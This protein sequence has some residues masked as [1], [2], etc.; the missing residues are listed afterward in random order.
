MWDLHL[1]HVLTAKMLRVNS[2]A[3]KARVHQV[4]RA[5]HDRGLEALVLYANGSVLGNQSFMHA[6]LRY[7]C[8]FD[9]H[10]TPAMLIVQPGKAPT[11]LTGNKP[12]MRAHLAERNL[13]FDDVRHVQPP[14]LGDEIVSILAVAGR[15]ARRIAYMGYNETPAPVWKSLEQGLPR[16][17]WIHD[18]APDIDKCRVRKTAVEM[19]FHRRA[20]EVCDAMFETLAREVAT[21]KHGYRLKAAMEHTARDSGCDYCDTWLTLA[22]RADVFRYYM[23]E[24]FNAPQAG[25]Q[26]L[27]GV[28]LTYDGHWGHSVRT[29]SIGRATADHRRIYGICRDM[30]EAALE[31]LRPGE[32]LRGVNA[33]MDDILHRHYAEHEVRRSRS[34]HG[35]GYAYEDPVV[36]LA[37][38]NPWDSPAATRGPIEIKPGM[39]M[40]LHPHL[41]VPNVAGAMIGDM[42]AVTETGYE[43]L[44]AFSRDLITW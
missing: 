37:F 30:Y 24:C 19:S 3:L 27:A 7:L 43:I 9:G 38:A 18:F 25:D 12:H 28:L 1:V 40:E 26:L 31:R 14:R 35:L 5:L 21:G 42:V 11:L 16:T 2:Q 17:E 22:P 15:G 41:F 34:G 6:Y 33:A 29:G 13:W 20:A 8:N 23:D 32:D 36:S 39:L 44:T 4:E 10:N